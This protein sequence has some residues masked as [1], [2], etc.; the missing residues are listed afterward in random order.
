MDQKIK[1]A[2]LVH[3]M[4]KLRQVTNVGE[5]ENVHAAGKM[6]VLLSGLSS[7]SES[8]LTT[9]QV[10]GIA[11]A[12]NITKLEQPTLLRQLAERKLIDHRESGIA[13]LGITSASVLSHT[14]NMFD[15]LRPLPAEQAVLELAEAV[16]HSPMEMREATQYVSDK[17]KLSTESAGVLLEQTEQIGF[18]DAEDLDSSRKLF[19]NGNLFRRG[20]AKK[21][22]AVLSSLTDADHRM[23]QQMEAQLI[24]SGCV[25]KEEAQHTLGESLFC[26]LQSIGLY[27]VNEVSNENEKVCFVTRPAAFGKYG[28]GDAFTDD[29]MNLA[30]AFVTCLK[31]GMTRRSSAQGR[32][33]ALQSLMRKLIAGEW[34]GPATAI[35]Q[36]YQ[37]LEFQRV[38]EI[39]RDE[40]GRFSMRLLKKEVGALALQVLTEGDASEQSLEPLFGASVSRYRDPESN[41]ALRRKT[42]NASQPEG[43]RC[44]VGVHSEAIGASV[45]QLLR[46]NFDFFLKFIYINNNNMLVDIVGIMRRNRKGRFRA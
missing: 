12:A 45:G 36:D 16:S 46:L 19:F 22:Q 18:L 23:V 31:Y 34:V 43:D 17:F 15:E 24:Q 6:G 37:V 39:K 3:H 10:D 26:K 35:G 5:F 4:E 11:R 20:T 28:G 30:K 38:V 1:G 27:D 32:I 41:R 9:Q 8:E 14:A 2:W 7:S 21:I 40:R 33:M 29:A 44:R 42:Q 13:V 25:T